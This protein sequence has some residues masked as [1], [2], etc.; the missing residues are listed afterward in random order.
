M[1]SLAPSGA[2]VR[3]SQPE[4]GYT[5][6]VDAEEAKTGSDVSTCAPSPSRKNMPEDFCAETQAWHFDDAM[7]AGV[8]RS[9]CVMQERKREGATAAKRSAIEAHPEFELAPRGCA[10]EAADDVARLE[11]RVAR[12]SQDARALQE[13]LRAGE[14]VAS[15]RL[16]AESE[17]SRARLRAELER[18]WR[19][20]E[21]EH[22]WSGLNGPHGASTAVTAVGAAAAAA[23]ATGAA[24]GTAL[25]ELRLAVEAAKTQQQIA[26]SDLERTR[27]EQASLAQMCS[28]L[29]EELRSL[30]EFC[31][32]E[33]KSTRSK[34]REVPPK[35]GT[36]ATAIS[37]T[38]AAKA[39][40]KVNGSLKA[41]TPM[42]TS[43]SS[44][45]S[46]CSS[47][48]MQLASAT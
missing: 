21:L 19:E 15:Q 27:Q 37:A 5:S 17:A 30:K 25:R 12:A 38:S 11:G 43:S 7:V 6:A 41:A 33:K 36:R 32:H 4:D 24:D 39:Q 16:A 22:A 44:W 47:D 31:Q 42:R 45:L 18:T 29:E 1:V 28:S 46:F 23:A 20:L 3:V 2:V 10:D 40:A 35:A 8:L 9:F 34:S 48:N 26:R 14:E 13:T